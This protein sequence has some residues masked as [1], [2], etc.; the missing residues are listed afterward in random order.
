MVSTQSL[1]LVVYGAGNDIPGRQ[2][3]PLIEAIHKAGAVRKLQHSAFTPHCLGNQERLGMWVVKARGVELVELHIADPAACTPGHGDTVSRSAI[4]VGG[5]AICFACAAGG[6]DGEAGPEQFDM[7]VFQ[8]QYVGAHARVAGQCQLAI[9]DQIH[10]NPAG[11]QGD[12]G[13][14][15]G[16]GCQ[17]GG[18]G[19]AGGIGCVDNAA[20]A[21]PAFPCQVVLGLVIAGKGNTTVDQPVDALAAM[22]DRKPDGIFVAET[23]PGVEGVAD[24]ILKRVIVIQHGCN[25]ALGPERCA[26]ADIGL[27]DDGDL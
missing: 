25:A 11:H 26:A 21:M 2:F 16:L 13:S 12:V 22:L 8:V 17:G 24:V 18:N 4:R 5:V 6:K 19:V 10:G 14:C 15:L 23:A 9:G 7:V 3:A 27:A 20:V 1:H